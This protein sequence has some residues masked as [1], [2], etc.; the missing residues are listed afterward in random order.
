MTKSVKILIAVL[1]CSVIAAGAVLGGVFGA[2][3]VADKRHREEEQAAYEAR[4]IAVSSVERE[5]LHGI[6]EDW[7][8]NLTND[9]LAQLEDAGDYVV[10]KSWTELIKV[11]LFD[12]NLQTAKITALSDA[13]KSEQGQKLFENFENNAELLIPLIRGVGFT[14]S[15]V[16]NLVYS[17][18]CAFVDKGAD[19]LTSARDTLVK[20][21]NEKTA[22]NVN[23]N[24]AAVNSELEYLNFSADEK[25]DI[26]ADLANAEN[27]IKEL[28]SFAYTT[29]I[30]T[31]TDKM[32]EI[33]ASEDGALS[34]ITD[35]EIQTVV[36]AMLGNVRELKQRMTTSE[37]AKLNKAIKTVTDNFEGNPSTSRIFSQIVRY[38]KFAYVVTDSIPNLAN[39]VTSAASVVDADFLRTV[40]AFVDSESKSNNDL[41]TANMSVVSA[42]ILKAFYEDID[43]TDL[44]ALLDTFEAQ[45]KEDYRRALPIVALDFYFNVLAYNDETDEIL[46]PEILDEDTVVE[47]A[48]FFLMYIALASFENKYYSYLDGTAKLKEV[49]DAAE[50]CP[51]KYY[52]ISNPYSA[53]ND[54]RNWFEYYIKETAKAMTESSAK[55]A[56][57]LKADLTACLDDY[58]AEGSSVK[59]DM[60]LLAGKPLISPLSD[61]ATEEEKQAQQEKTD[62]Y[63]GLAKS[64][65]ALGLAVAILE[66][67]K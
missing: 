38:A 7:T 23:K 3:A 41:K 5:F 33:I 26:L 54:V 27:A 47:G 10:F 36:D 6:N 55:L 52:E 67:F 4:K 39:V 34:D 29:S 58:Y 21:K 59:S 65:R 19:V 11:E 31:L 61:D 1:V 32:V 28:T 66:L 12:S 2:R 37:I 60:L 64:S 63:Y 40:R 49:K 35:G 57:I 51:F 50:W 16:S 30:T 56:P 22:V 25:K 18:L 20:V 15:D 44:L 24:L 17:L 62:E 8:E 9:E 13:L 42:R 45:A 46:H 53:E 48:M 43:K 14:S